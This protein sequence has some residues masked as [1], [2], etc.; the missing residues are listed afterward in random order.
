MKSPIAVVI[1]L[2]L[3][4]AALSLGLAFAEKAMPV[5][6]DTNA[7]VNNTTINESL[8]N[9]TAE[10]ETIENLTTN[11]TS[12]NETTTNLTL[13]NMTTQQNDSNPFSKVKG[14]QVRR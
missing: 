4:F 8:K 5:N 9:A 14:R 7:T 3:A 2:L 10:N 11:I 1:A 12:I 13:E 6:E